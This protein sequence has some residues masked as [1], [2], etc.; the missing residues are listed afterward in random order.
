M[1]RF[2]SWLAARGAVGALARQVAL[3]CR[4]S[5]ATWI[6]PTD[7]VRIS[8][9]DAAYRNG[10]IARFSHAMDLGTTGW[11]T[12]SRLPA[13]R[14]VMRRLLMSTQADAVTRMPTEVENGDILRI[15]C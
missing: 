9:T 3:G 1:H 7:S 11:C 2:M 8:K 14:R 15:F 13:L 12:A 10:H 6:E 4:S 5:E